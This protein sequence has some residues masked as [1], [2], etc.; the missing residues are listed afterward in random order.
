MAPYGESQTMQL[1][2]PNVVHRP[3]LSIGQDYSLTDKI[4]MSLFERAEDRR[5]AKFRSWHGL[6]GVRLKPMSRS[7]LPL[8]AA[9]VVANVR[10][11]GV[12]LEP[13][14]VSGK[15]K[16]VTSRRNP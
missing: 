3:G 4:S 8:K 6:S 7:V 16:T 5:G 11:S 1:V 9:Q 12:L 13:I 15:E 2:K 10:Q 14:G